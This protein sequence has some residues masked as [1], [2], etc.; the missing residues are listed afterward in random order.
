MDGAPPPEED[1]NALPIEAR[2]AHKNWK[3]RVSGYET[4]SKAFQRSASEDDPAFRPYVNSG[5]VLKKIVLDA[6]AVAQEK[7][8]DA[9]VALVKFAGENAARTR[10]DVLPAV[11]DKCL[12]S[13]RA[14]TKNHAIELVLQY[15]EMENTA[16][17]CVR[18]L[19]A[20]LG[21]KQPKTVAGCVTALKEI[22]RV[23]GIQP[24]SPALILKALPKIFGHTD[25][26]VRAEGT[27]L[28]QA[29]YQCIGAAIQPSLADL[30]PVQVK[31]LTEGFEKLDADGKGKGS[32]VPERF[33]REEARKREAAPP[34]SGDVPDGMLARCFTAR[35]PDIT[36][37]EP[38]ELDPR[39]FAEEVDIVPQIP[40]NFQANLASSKWKE[41]K[42]A[43]DDL[44]AVLQKAV[45]IRD[46]PELGDTIKALAGKM[47]DVNINCVITA[48]N[49]LE[50][51][52]KGLMDAFAKH[53]EVV[54]PPML[55]RMKERKATVTDALGTALDAI[56]ATTTISDILELF[57]PPLTNKSPQVKEGTVKFIHRC[58]MNATKP[59][60]PPQV[61]PLADALA[62]LLSD[63]TEGVRDVAAQAMGCLM[64][65]VGE[66][67]MNPILE[68]LDDLRK[69]KVKENFEKATVKCKAGSA[70]P[71]KPAAP[72]PAA[73][74]PKKK[75][76]AAKKA[77]PQPAPEPEEAA[78][79]AMEPPKKGPPARLLA[80]KPAAASPAAAAP[81]AKKPPAAAAA[82][83]AAASSKGGAGPAPGSLDTF[84]YK[85][86]P[87]AAED[88][89]AE[90]IPANI[91]NDLGDANWKLRLAALDEMISWLDGGAVETVDSEVMVRFLAKK[92]WNE[93]N[94]QVS[95]KVY[96]VLGMLADRCPTF[97]RSSVALAVGHLCDKL[98]DIKL[99][100]P[101][102]ETLGVFA[103]KTSLSFVLNQA[104]EPMGK[105]K[106]PK[107]IAD[108]IAWINT[109]LQE[110]GIAGLSLRALIDFLKEG[111][112]NS[113]AAVRTSA[114]NCLVT[115]K[116]FAGAGIKDLVQDLNPQ[117]LATITS[118][119]DKAE[120]TPAPTP[121]RQSAEAAAAPA[122]GA[123]GKSG[124]GG[125][126]PLD[127]LFP[128]VELDKLVSAA[129][130][131]DAKS[132]AWKSRK[133]ALESL[134]AILDVGANKRLKPTM[135][136]IREVLKSRVT[137]TNKSV[138]VLALDIIARI[139][140][141]MNK[142]FEKYS[143]LFVAPVCS[144]LADQKAH[145]R[146]AGLVTLSAI[147]TACEGLDSMVPG[148]VTGLET[149]NPLLR[150]ALTGWLADYFA[151]HE[152]APLPDLLPLATPLLACLEDKSGDVRKGAVAV[153]SHV[154]GQVGYDKVANLTG[155]L[156][157][158][159]RTAVVGLLKQAAQNAPASAAPPARAP[160]APVAAAKA[161][162]T[163]APTPP[164]AE[165]AASPALS[166]A[167]PGGGMASRATGV[168]RGIATIPSRPASRAESIHGDPAAPTSRLAKPGLGGLR[169]PTVGSAP[170]STSPAPASHP[171][172]Y[173]IGSSSEV[174]RSRLAKDMGRWI[175]EG[176][177][178]RKD[179]N[180][181]LR[182]QME[183]HVAEEVIKHLFSAGH[184]PVADYV[185]GIGEM[186]ESFTKAI[187]DDLEEMVLDELR[188]ALLSNSDLVLKYVSLRVHEPPPNL[189][190]KCLDL[191]DNVLSFFRTIEYQLSDAEAQCF[192][193]SIIHKLGDARE[194]VRNRVA[195]L[196]QSLSRVYAYSRIFQLLLEH[197][198]KSKVAKTRQGSLDEISG[199]LKRSGLGACDPA[200]AFPVVATL[201]SDKD[202]NVRKAAL[203]AL[204]EAY[205]L[206]GDKIWTM[207]GSLSPKDKT[208]LEER[209][210]R[211]PAP[212]APAVNEIPPTPAAVSRVAASSLQRP[213]SPGLGSSRFG[214]PAGLPR[215]TS[216]SAPASSRLARP[217]SPSSRL[218][219]ARS[220][221]PAPSLR[222]P[223][224]VGLPRAR[225]TSMLPSRLG[226]PRAR[227]APIQAPEPPQEEAYAVNGY[228]NGHA[229]AY[230]E[231]PAPEPAPPPAEADI[232][233][234]ISSILSSDPGRS[235]EALKKIQKILDIAPE[236]AHTS[237]QFRELSDHT[238]G[239]IETITLQMGHVFDKT[240]Q[241]IE[242]GNF[243]L[244]KHLIQ[245]L[246]SFC[247]HA[248]L[249]E[250]LTVEI[251]QSLLEEL[252]L[253]LL[254]T[255]ES[256]EPKIKD[257]SRFINMLI[258]RLFAVARRVAIFRALFGLLL[259]LVKPF[260]SHGTLPDAPEARV[261][262][263]V[264][265]CVWKL[266]R[267]IPG[268][269][270][271]NAL[272]PVEL[273]PAIEHF[274]Q[275]IPPNEWR[276]RATNRVPSGDMPLRTIK[277]IIQ[278]IV[279][280]YGSDDTYEVLTQAFDDPSATIVYPYVFRILNS[281]A[282][283]NA[284]NAANANGNGS[285]DS[286][287]T[288]TRSTTNGSVDRPDIRGSVYSAGSPP[289]SS[290]ASTS[291]SRRHAA[292]PERS[293]T[294][295]H[296][297]R[298]P[299]VH[300]PLMPPPPPADEPDP[301]VLLLKIIDHI[302]SE[303]T[304]ALHKEGITE[305]YQ[306]T[307]TYPQKQ[308]KVDKLL[309]ATGPAFRKYIARALASRAAED[310]A[311]E[312]ERSDTL[313][314][315]ETVKRESVQSVPSSPA[316]SVRTNITTSAAS[317][318]RMSILGDP[319]PGEDRL[320]R[321]HD[322][323][324]Y[325]R[326]VAAKEESRMSRASM[327][328]NGSAGSGLPA[329]RSSTALDG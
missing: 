143:R 287:R 35:A 4:L 284:A 221:S 314:Q 192:I 318:R 174:K 83:A 74:A 123:A 90:M 183:G 187:S 109:S 182:S 247:D 326:N 241:L 68:P 135:G 324:Q 78:S 142:P 149:A 136:E 188:G 19:V 292:S 133:E 59:P 150:G 131:S 15:V 184:D 27:A 40:A 144:V 33:T 34:D 86:T 11:V 65:I 77:A 81:A 268:D 132:D 124:G 3:A 328:S 249:A 85:H 168:R 203:G 51:L 141:G 105:Q 55:D 289:R 172:G 42:E 286:V 274:L 158:A 58:L 84:K 17:G 36:L 214:A 257:L 156:K 155:S 122:G 303:T 309:E 238:E 127:D 49:C 243:R 22:V 298:S 283:T 254:H 219:G 76:A 299:T 48:A 169:K 2:L 9:V 21:A 117:L 70:A 304:G 153:L 315:L 53:K 204:S 163:K 181:V 275:S 97:A 265:K 98:G 73:A 10:E 80:K 297:S 63:S 145:I 118:E 197:G 322:V 107:V 99:K 271:K 46:A 217:A 301:D 198:L 38:E 91:A 216:P 100:K 206:V 170:K 230:E 316:P 72:P 93:K 43:L 240:E 94:F 246:N 157:P 310:Q 205:V 222:P 125:G 47:T 62:T 307:K 227:P 264:L 226:A 225:P 67:A 255:D 256:K 200:K 210:R 199:V 30:K 41:R 189:V 178:V 305:L 294:R 235:V 129:M 323:F 191:L 248:V 211:V 329:S 313:S 252:T 25:K 12:G 296:R 320:S 208:Q 111:L 202:P 207:V 75:P 276:A 231:P 102:G 151:E 128:R 232:T 245:T 32:L 223:S 82:A 311:R 266:A 110:F 116:L 242:S 64:K 295:S 7:G 308:A 195:L 166:V 45:R 173:F 190:S 56:F 152:G 108:S 95:T 239:L 71:P 228:T 325:R 26:T 126:D 140:A 106:A 89:A 179:L 5:D 92:S 270:E 279:A 250:S 229:D 8:L 175:V 61:K 44:L 263:L 251:L 177:P 119:F 16:D 293:P 306:F 161:A 134:Q 31:E 186:N 277:V 37:A 321:L 193:P 115:V 20:G 139:A 259:Q 130:L 165:R 96:T 66:R 272:D 148:L 285:G 101:A 218:P 312:S 281:N 234:T 244:A 103:E 220:A 194:P 196:I 253:R 113:N 39:S 185:I 6:N 112:K 87:E 160:A 13:T 138:Q 273:F 121:T 233:I 209:L 300:Q 50:A 137:D 164:P 258:L 236:A 171:V 180:D 317:P 154:I 261:A 29:I 79:P 23:F 60:A 224:T 290:A 201:I 237:P 176:A 319:L 262:E 291:S 215:P 104:Y 260:P 88:L 302:S 18:D 327:T 52:A 212:N 159:S 1:F 54:I 24:V 288:R 282:R 57:L 147:A 267:N 280:H 14:G 213:Q 162:A 167:K 269:L 120:G 146:S 114:T 69:A 28:C 278:H